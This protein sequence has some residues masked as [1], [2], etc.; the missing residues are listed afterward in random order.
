MGCDG[1]GSCFATL[2]DTHLNFK[3]FISKFCVLPCQRL[4]LHN[5]LVIN[6]NLLPFTRLNLVRVSNS[7][8][9]IK[10]PKWDHYTL[11]TYQEPI[12]VSGTMKRNCL[13]AMSCHSLKLALQPAILAHSPISPTTTPW[14]NSNPH[15]SSSKSAISPPSMH[16]TTVWPIACNFPIIT[17]TQM[18][19][20]GRR[21][22]LTQARPDYRVRRRRRELTH[23]QTSAVDH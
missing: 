11:T 19:L 16:H 3:S 17:R 18:S 6:K 7:V 12:L 8:F 10:L 22:G 14:T 20:T 2:L 23:F 9:T 21:W 15:P 5:F 4:A 1:S 13:G